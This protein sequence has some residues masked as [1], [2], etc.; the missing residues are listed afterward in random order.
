MLKETCTRMFIVALFE[1]AGE[2]EPPG[3]LSPEE[4]ISK[5]RCSHTMEYY[6]AGQSNRLGVH[7]KT[8]MDL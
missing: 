2:L 5:M 4:Q 8:G 7:R 3:Y 6:T 1:V